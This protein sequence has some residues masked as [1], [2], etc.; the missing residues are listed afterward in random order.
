MPIDT[1]IDDGVVEHRRGHRFDQKAV[2][3]RLFLVAALRQHVAAMGRDHDQQR[4]LE[5]L[6]AVTDLLAGLPAVQARHL[7]VD[8]NGI[9]GG[10]V[11][12]QTD[13]GRRAAVGQGH[14]PAQPSGH[15]S[16]QVARE[17]VVVDHQHAQGDGL[18]Q[19]QR[20]PF[21]TALFA[22]V[23]IAMFVAVFI[24]DRQLDL[25]VEAAAAALRAVQPQPAAHQAHQALADRQAQPGAAEAARGR[26]LGLREAAEDA[27]L[28]LGRDA[29]ARIAHRH[30]QRHR[31]GATLHHLHRDHHL[32]LRGELDRVAA[33]IDQH[34]L[35]A[36]RV[37]DQHRRQLR[38]DVEQHLDLLARGAGRQDHGEVAQQLIGSEGVQVQRHLAGLDLGEIQDVVQQTQ[39]RTRGAL[40]L[41]GVIGL[42]HRQFSFLQQRQHAQ[43]GIHRRADLVAHVGQE[44]TFRI[45]RFQRRLGGAHELGD[46]DAVTH[47]VAIGHA[48]FADAQD[49]AVTQALGQLRRRLAVDGHAFG[50]PVV[51]TTDSLGVLTAFG[52]GADDLLEIGARHHQVGAQGV[53]VAV[54]LVAQHHAVVGVEQR[55]GI[56]QSVDRAAQ[57]RAC[58]LHLGLGAVACA[59]VGVGGDEAATRHRAAAD[60]QRC[61][62]GAHTLEL[63]RLDRRTGAGDDG[64]HGD[65]RVAGAVFATL[66]IEADHVLEAGDRALEQRVG[67]VEQAPKLGVRG[68]QLQVAVENAQTAGQV[69]DHAGENFTV[70][71]HLGFQPVPRGDVLDGADQPQRPAVRRFKLAH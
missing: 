10:T 11:F 38:V 4:R 19:A 46:V 32:A 21:A 68:H 51:H 8:E 3:P 54:A 14:L 64:L 47:G 25:E 49:A 34:L 6:S 53:E 33:Q 35:Q 57:Q 67:K 40:G 56:V 58:P 69:L 16:H 13:Q 7:P 60:L 43:D 63:V 42:P 37:A 30:L 39:Q 70:A 31:F 2:H 24:P 45:G 12:L 22:A 48:A 9:E 27:L 65:L 36:Q 23:F 41:A 44:L 15:A 18:A 29:D 66:G 17:R 28:I 71:P 52:T 26:G 5:D 61:A 50:H 1:R 55:V 62:V 20:R 59:D